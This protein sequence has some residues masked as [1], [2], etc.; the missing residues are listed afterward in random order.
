MLLFIIVGFTI[1]KIRD[2]ITESI[3]LMIN[4]SGVNTELL[5]EVP[6]ETG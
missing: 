1:D 3:G 5:Y 2:L 6:P 4:G